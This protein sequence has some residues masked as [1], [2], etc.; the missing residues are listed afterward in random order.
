[1]FSQGKV[2]KLKD[3]SATQILREVNFGE[4]RSAKS[5]ILTNLEALAM[6]FDFYEIL[7]FFGG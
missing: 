6:N 4:S 1:M 2:W 5:V 7:H 3:F